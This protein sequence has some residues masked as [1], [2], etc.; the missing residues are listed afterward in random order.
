MTQDLRSPLFF[1]RFIPTPPPPADTNCL[2]WLTFLP[3]AG[4]T[5]P[6]QWDSRRTTVT[7]GGE[8]PPQES[9]VEQSK[10]MGALPCPSPSL[11][12]L[13]HRERGCSKL[14]VWNT[15]SNLNSALFRESVDLN[16]SWDHTQRHTG[17][18]ISIFSQIIY[19][20]GTFICD[21]LGKDIWLGAS[22]LLYLPL[23]EFTL[24]YYMTD[25]HSIHHYCFFHQSPVGH[26]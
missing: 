16:K 24:R 11:V 4:E 26:R 8:V 5:R 23:Q 18:A 22:S 10:I 7:W 17:K 20:L 13:G 21:V 12:D 19:Q 3:L 14:D 6:L 9:N 2:A 1:Q 15:H 25:T